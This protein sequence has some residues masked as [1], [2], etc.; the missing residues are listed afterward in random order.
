MLPREYEDVSNLLTFEQ[1]N[2]SA[3]IQ[4]LWVFSSQ[5]QDQ[6]QSSNNQVR[7]HW[8]VILQDSDTKYWTAENVGTLLFQRVDNL[9]DG[10]NKRKEAGE[11]RT[12]SRSPDGIGITQL[13][14]IEMTNDKTMRDLVEWLITRRA[15][16]YHPLFDNCQRFSDSLREFLLT[17][18]VS[19]TTMSDAAFD[20][21]EGTT[22]S[23]SR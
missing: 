2:E 20:R 15:H 21:L 12:K 7:T 8:W 23:W 14:R 9:D 3:V 1:I 10:M 17:K 13:I 22:T 19:K 6:P 18:E 4:K 16:V 11:S 5:L